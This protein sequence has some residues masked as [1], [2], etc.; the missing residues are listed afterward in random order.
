MNK[1]ASGSDRNYVMYY[2]LGNMV[3]NINERENR[4]IRKTVLLNFMVT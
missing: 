3:G 1:I 4:K 2:W